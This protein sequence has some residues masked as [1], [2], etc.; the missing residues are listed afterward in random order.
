VTRLETATPKCSTAGGEFH[1]SWSRTVMSCLTW[2]RS[3]S[4]LSLS[5]GRQVMLVTIAAGFV[6]GFSR[7]APDVTAAFA[8]D[9]V[10]YCSSRGGR[11]MLPPIQGHDAVCPS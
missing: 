4:F 9:V 5:L 11:A 7:G 2:P 6:L 10:Y 8:W 1:S 3:T